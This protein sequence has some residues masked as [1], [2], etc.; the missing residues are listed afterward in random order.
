MGTVVGVEGVFGADDAVDDQ[1]FDS[2]DDIFL[3]ADFDGLVVEVVLEIF[4]A[5]GVA[6]F[7]LPE[8]FLLLL[9]ADVGEVDLVLG[10]FG[11][12]FFAGGPEIAVFVKKYIDFVVD[13]G[14]DADVE[15]S[16]LVE[17]RAL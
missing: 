5:E 6:F 3:E 2:R 8:I 1:I 4:E 16:A 13:E 14:P 7:V 11:G 12:V 9:V 10:Y 17:E 15:L